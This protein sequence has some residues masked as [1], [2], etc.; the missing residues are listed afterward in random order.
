MTFVHVD[1]IMPTSML[2]SPDPCRVDSRFQFLSSCCAVGGGG[3]TAL[4]QGEGGGE[5]GGRETERR[6]ERVQER[7]RERE[8]FSSEV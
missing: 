5:G 6:R 4:Q 7:E 3:R 8:R 1:D 2:L